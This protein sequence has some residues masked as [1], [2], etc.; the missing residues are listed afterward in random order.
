M[1]LLFLLEQE[2]LRLRFGIGYGEEE[3]VSFSFGF[4]FWLF[5]Y[6]QMHIFI[7]S[8]LAHDTELTL[9]LGPKLLIKGYFLCCLLCALHGMGSYLGRA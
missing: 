4:G 9:K 6:T 3:L 7:R 8:S 1:W 5:R 2:Q